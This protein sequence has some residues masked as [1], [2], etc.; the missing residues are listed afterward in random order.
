[1]LAIMYYEEKIIDGVLCWRSH[2][3]GEWMPFSLEALTKK[4]MEERDK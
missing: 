3:K 2:P 1:M 4:L